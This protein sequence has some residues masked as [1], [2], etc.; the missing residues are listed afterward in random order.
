M[1]CHTAI[2]VFNC[3]T[4]LFTALANDAYSLFQFVSN[5]R[6][7]QRQV[8]RTK[9]VIETIATFAVVA[10]SVY[11]TWAD[12][13]IESRLE[14]QDDPG[15]SNVAITQVARTMLS[16]FIADMAAA[17]MPGVQT[18]IIYDIQIA[19]VGIVTVL[20]KNFAQSL[21]AK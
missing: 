10:W 4:D 6:W 20:L 12:D 15:E 11:I 1:Q 18:A 19:S 7:Q 17:L 5:P 16:S 21:D 9:L 8:N 13:L 2:E 3:T 14:Q